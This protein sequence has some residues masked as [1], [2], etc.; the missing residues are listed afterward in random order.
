[1]DAS[2]EVWGLFADLY[3]V[4]ALPSGSLRY[5][6]K[7]RFIDWAASMSNFSLPTDS[8][9]IWDPLKSGWCTTGYHYN[10]KVGQIYLLL[11]F[12]IEIKSCEN[13]KEVLSDQK[14]VEKI[15]DDLV[16]KAK[17]HEMLS[18][19]DMRHCILYLK[20]SEKYED[21]ISSR[22]KQDIVKHYTNKISLPASDNIDEAIFQIR[23]NIQE[24]WDTEE[25]FEFYS[26]QHEWY[27]TNNHQ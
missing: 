11:L 26:F 17:E 13:S 16:E 6:S 19:Y 20:F 21:I 1:M 10:M 4:Y 8:D 3:Y 23:E 18:P 24:N 5:T 9:T 22:A 25:P 15:L 7:R 12:S 27:R 2:N 14:V